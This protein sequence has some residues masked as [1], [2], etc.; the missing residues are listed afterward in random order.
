MGPESPDS[1]PPRE[2]D[3]GDGDQDLEVS[4]V[5]RPRTRTRKPSMYKVLMLNDDYTPMEFVVHVLERFFAKTRDEAT[6]VMLQV[7]QRGV[8]VC[9]VFT[10]EVAESKVTQV[11]DLARQN[12]HPLQCTIEKD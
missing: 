7:H 2:P 3:R 10:Y 8:G 5:V 9:G 1:I 11:M 12:Q 4:V 6:S